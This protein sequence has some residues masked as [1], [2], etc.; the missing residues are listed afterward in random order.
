MR[1]QLEIALHDRYVVDRELGRGGM[2][3]VWLSRDLKH[4]RLVAI[5]VLHPELAATLGPERFQREIRTTARLDHPHILPVLDSGE[6]AGLLW[7]TMPYV[8]GESLRDRLRRESQ[9]PLEVALDIT[10]QVASALDYAHHA[11]V[12]HRDLKPENILLADDQARVADFG[13]AKAL[14]EAGADQLTESGLAVGTPAYMSPEQASGGQVDSRSDVYALGCVLYEMLAG[15]PPFLAKSAQALMARHAMEAVPSVRIVRNTVPEEVEDAIFAAMAKVPAD[16][17]QSAAQFAEILG[18]PLGATASRRATIRHT[19]SRRVPTGFT[20]SYEAEAP[21]PPWWRKPWA[22]AVMAVVLVAGG[23]LGWKSFAGSRSAVLSP[24]EAALKRKIAVLY[25]TSDDAALGPIADGLTEGL[26]ASLRAARLDVISRNGVLPFRGT[27]TPV[28][29]IAGRLQV[30]TLVRGSVVKEGADRVRVTTWLTDAYGNDQGGRVN[31]V[32]PRDSLLAAGSKVAE[33]A[34]RKLREHLGESIQ[35]AEIQARAGN[36][37]SFALL[38]RGEKARNDAEQARLSEPGRALPL[39]DQADSLLAR[40]TEADPAWADPLIVRGEVALQRAA[41]ADRGEMLPVIQAGMRYAE[42]ALVRE[43]TSA[44][45][46]ALKGSLNYAA[47]RVTPPDQAALRKNLLDSAEAE[48]LTATQADPSL[49]GAYATLSNIYYERKDVHSALKMALSAWTEDKYLSNSAAILNRLFFSNYDTENFLEAR[50]YCDIGR[51]RFP[52]NPVFTQCSLWLML[53]PDAPRDVP[54]AWRLAA[55]LDSL[56]AGRPE[57]ARARESRLGRILVAGAIGKMSNGVPSP[58][59]DS[60]RRV[61]LAA[62][63]DRNID[64]GRELPGYE[65]VIRVQMGDV[66]EAIALLKEYVASNPDHSFN[67]GGNV[68]WWW[69]DIRSRPEFQALLARRG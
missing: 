15:E 12:V 35:L 44:R 65:A 11:G 10:R 32:V 25:F 41:L 36:Q 16:R 29:S 60:A 5:K 68:H 62:R 4:D 9:L 28:D 27:E 51:F 42:A 59:A 19:A 67:V 63:A 46:L 31:F 64:P 7:Y 53:T 2:A 34:S 47:W 61:L 48:L 40:A 58:L 55:R 3:R 49:A 1:A 43:P 20:R 52:A 23:Y 37:E 17:P 69:R 56:N 30:G 39:L 54:Q 38:Q 6:A 22:M 45:A 21:P 24:A 50:R 57:Q 26:I 33:E 14:S 13:V 8:R 18:M 66:D